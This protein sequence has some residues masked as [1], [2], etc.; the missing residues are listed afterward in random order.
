MPQPRS[1]M[2]RK[3]STAGASTKKRSVSNLRK[4][5][6]SPRWKVRVRNMPAVKKRVACIQFKGQHCGRQAGQRQPQLRCV[7]HQSW[8]SMTHCGAA[9]K[10]STP[11]GKSSTSAGKSNWTSSNSSRKPSG[12]ADLRRSSSSAVEAFV[13]NTTTGYLP[14]NFPRQCSDSSKSLWR[15]RALFSISRY[16]T[17]PL[18]SL[19]CSNPAPLPWPT[20]ASPKTARSRRRMYSRSLASSVV[21][22]R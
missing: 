5:S 2:S 14:K 19:S 4:K 16:V 7:N 6:N 17:T 10:P 12:D 22:S 1:A 20:S 9:K 21:L 8:P 3:G 18:G 15:D 13:W 11:P